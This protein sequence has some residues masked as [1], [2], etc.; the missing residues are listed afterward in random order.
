MILFVITLGTEY[1]VKNRASNQLSLAHRNNVSVKMSS[2][3][4]FKLSKLIK[5]ATGIDIS[6]VPFLGPFK[7]DPL[8]YSVSTKDILSPLLS[9]TYDSNSPLQY[10]G[11]KLPRDLTSHF[12]AEIGGKQGIQITYAQKVLELEFPK[13]RSSHFRDCSQRFL[14]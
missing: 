4:F 3:H 8:A 14:A 6:S 13:A 11:N 10:Y 7:I 9:K 5:L 2:V 1:N 12:V